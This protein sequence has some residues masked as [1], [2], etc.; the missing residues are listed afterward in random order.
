MLSVTSVTKTQDLIDD[1]VT[2]LIKFDEDDSRFL[3]TNF[4]KEDGK[5]RRAAS[6]TRNKDGQTKKKKSQSKRRKHEK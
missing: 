4:T 6:Q 1:F 3:T 5:D 2:E